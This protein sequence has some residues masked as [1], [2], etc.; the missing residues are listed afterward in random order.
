MPVIGWTNLLCLSIVDLILTDNVLYLFNT[1]TKYISFKP[2][3]MY[4]TCKASLCMHVYMYI[5]MYVCT[6]VRMYLCMYVHVHTPYCKAQPTLS[7]AQTV[8]TK[9]AIITTSRQNH[10]SNRKPLY[11]R[12]GKPAIVAAKALQC[13]RTAAYNSDLHTVNSDTPLRVARSR[14]SHESNS[15]HPLRSCTALQILI[16]LS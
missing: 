2:T 13:G 16:P 12:I 5:C 3:H 11:V 15:L 1:S 10:K 14:S 7:I 4:P 6:Y 8:Q 9:K